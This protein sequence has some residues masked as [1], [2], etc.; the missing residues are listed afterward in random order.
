MSESTVFSREDRAASAVVAEHVELSVIV[1]VY[2]QW[3]LL[4]FLLDAITEQ[5]NAPVFEVLLVDNG[6]DVREPLPRQYP[7]VRQLHCETR[8]SYAAR[9]AGARV[10]RGQVLVFTDADCR[11]ERDWLATIWREMAAGTKAQLLAGD[12]RLVPRNL[13]APNIFESYDMMTG[14]QQARYVRR[15]YA[16]TANLAVPREV[17]RNLEGFN[18]RAY[19]GADAEFCRRAVQRGVPLV[20]C[21]EMVIE[22]PAR[23]SLSALMTKVRR[24]KGGQLAQPSKRERLIWAAR[25]FAPPAR[26][27]WRIMR[28]PGFSAGQK[29]GAALVQAR[30]W[31]TE[32]AEVLR[33][34]TGGTPEHR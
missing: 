25:A 20:Y 34:L 26:A 11:P 6:S 19:S 3:H 5:R 1:P 12:I 9:N 22:H 23:A 32:M 21:P 31:L 13:L 30:L 7:F 8:G 33:L 2:N 17:F 29:L 18:A 27:W 10:A 24:V 15:G 28:R 4:P 14:M 16:I